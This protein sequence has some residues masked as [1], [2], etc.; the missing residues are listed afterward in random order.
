[1][2]EKF[3]IKNLEKLYDEYLVVFIEE[4]LEELLT[5][6]YEFKVTIIVIPGDITGSSNIGVPMDFLE[7]I[8]GKFL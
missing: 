8:L 3:L 7:Q 4:F 2:L 5:D 1:M 6:C